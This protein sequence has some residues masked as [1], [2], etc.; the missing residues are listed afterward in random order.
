MGYLEFIEQLVYHWG[1]Y[2]NSSNIF[3]LGLM[4]K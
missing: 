1:L 2:L 4:S 3:R